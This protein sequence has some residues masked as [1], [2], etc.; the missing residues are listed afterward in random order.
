M[1]F[2]ALHYLRY[3][4]RTL[5]HGLHFNAR[6]SLEM[7]IGHVI[8]LIIDSPLAI[9]FFLVI[10]LFFGHNK[11]QT[12]VARSSIETEYRALVETT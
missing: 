9:V 6:S 4:E 2:C 7:V 10:L 1:Q 3:I 5:I 12:V 8:L 11:K